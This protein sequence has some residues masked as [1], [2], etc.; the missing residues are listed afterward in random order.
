M[1]VLDSVVIF[2]KNICKTVG[3]RYKFA[4]S[5]KIWNLTGYKMILHRKPVTNKMKQE[6]HIQVRQKYLMIW[7]HSCEWD[8]WRGEFVLERPSSE[9]QSSSVAMECWS[10]EH[11]VFVVEMYF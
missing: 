4:R 5:S 8:R 6:I 10:V 7:Q 11:R 9:T 2:C 3:I 1:T